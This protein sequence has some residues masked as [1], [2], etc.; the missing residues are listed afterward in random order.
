MRRVDVNG[1]TRQVPP[2]VDEVW[3]MNPWMRRNDP[4]HFR[5]RDEP[6]ANVRDCLVAMPGS[7]GD[8]ATRVAAFRL[9]GAPSIVRVCP[10]SCGHGYPMEPWALSPIPEFCEREDLALFVDFGERSDYPWS[11]LVAFARSYPR[12]AIV[13]LGAPFAGPTAARALDATPNL[14]FD[15]SGLD[16]A[17][18]AS[19]V[20][21]LAKSHGAYRLVYGSGRSGVGPDDIAAVL[22]GEDSDTVL[23]VT[24]RRLDKGTWGN[25]FL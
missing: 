17:S 23:S 12:L 24:A 6:T 18:G 13:A 21:S 7:A 8:L 16:G 11:E 4:A 19:L 15:T 5:G 10:G 1:R 22:G 14:I 25:E 2:G 3:V 20:A 9:A